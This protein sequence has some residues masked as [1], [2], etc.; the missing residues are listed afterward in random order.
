MKAGR[1]REAKAGKNKKQRKKQKK[2]K[3]AGRNKRD[4]KKSRL[5]GK[6][7]RGRRGPPRGNPEEE[8]HETNSKMRKLKENCSIFSNYVFH[9][10][11]D[12]KPEN[13]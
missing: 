6:K 8:N 4:P 13:P 2:K 12:I 7:Q 11:K 5:K 9:L 3:K 10:L 1:N